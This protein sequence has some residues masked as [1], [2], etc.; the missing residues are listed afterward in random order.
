MKFKKG[1]P[2]TSIDDMIPIMKKNSCFYNNDVLTDGICLM[3]L[4]FGGVVQEIE[5]RNFYYAVEDDE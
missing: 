5:N 2:I 1:V 3:I 4:F